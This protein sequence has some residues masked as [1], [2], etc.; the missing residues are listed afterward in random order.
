M[1]LVGASNWFIQAPFVL[2]AVARGLI[3]AILAYGT[4]VL[5]KIYIFDG[6]SRSPD[7]SV[8]PD[9]VD[10]REPH[11][12]AACGRGHPGQL[13]NRLVCPPLLHP[14]LKPCSYAVAARGSWRLE[15]HFGPLVPCSGTCFRI[16]SPLFQAPLRSAIR[17]TGW[18]DPV[19]PSEPMEIVGS[20]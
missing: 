19:G 11:V 17:N 5:A 2:E 1:K 15:A 9:S 6:A 3:G 13:D 18:P 7:L 12:P 16:V 4:L 14:R 8:D 10:Q 20:W